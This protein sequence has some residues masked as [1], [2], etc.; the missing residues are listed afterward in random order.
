MSDRV[1]YPEDVAAEF[2]VSVR[3]VKYGALGRD[4]PWRKVGRVWWMTEE[5]FLR[6]F[7]S[8]AIL[9]IFRADSN[10]RRWPLWC[11]RPK[12]KRCFGAALL[13][14]LLSG[15]GEPSFP[16]A[17]SQSCIGGFTVQYTPD[18]GYVCTCH[19]LMYQRP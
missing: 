16:S 2:R 15:C 14:L 9:A 11:G 10:G 3:L 12:I 7:P 19:A 4:L 18:D 13:S 1:L 6:D 8:P 17:C 5:S